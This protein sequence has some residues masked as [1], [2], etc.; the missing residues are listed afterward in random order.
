MF[1][2][3]R[4]EINTPIDPVSIVPITLCY[5]SPFGPTMKADL[6]VT[7]ITQLLTCA[8]NGAPKHGHAMRDVGMIFEGAFAIA[9][10]KFIAVGTREEVE[11]QYSSG[12][13]ID[14]VGKV[15]SPGFVDPH[16]H[17][18]F[19]G[20]RLDEFEL[21][22]QG[23]DY[24]EILKHG[25]GIISTVRKTREA[26]LKEL[27][28]QARCRL[29]KMLGCGTTTAEIKTGYGLDLDTEL[30]MLRVIDEL[31]RT[32]PIEIVPTFL[33]AHAVPPEFKE[34]AEGYIKL[35]CEEMLPA[36]W[37]WYESSSFS[38]KGIP[39]FADIFCERNTFDLNLTR[40]VLEAAA[41]LGFGLK[42]HVDQFTNLGG[43]EY[44]IS[45]NATSID[46]L[47]AISEDEIRLL[48]ASNTIG[49]VIPTEG[50][51]AGKTE[52]A[53]ARR[54]IDAD[55]AVAVTT[56]YNPGSAPCPSQQMAMSIACRYQ[57]LMPAEAFN[58]ATINAAFAV[59]LGRTHG[60]IEVGKA[61]DFAIYDTND[62]RMLVYEFGGPFAG[63]VW[64][65]GRLI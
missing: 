48:A 44:S 49:V 58:A 27:V 38:E 31:N 55:C 19:A 37:S 39:F 50:F 4:S 13:T 5:H 36:A 47:D 12:E 54:M 11:A 63:S 10:G 22:I 41:G 21:K 8:S 24:L 65:Q 40:Q 16:T 51:N 23:A 30:K 60:S 42:A 57:K 35:I 53:P 2:P 25:G 62:Y 15:V 20:D 7:N 46:H 32:H 18:V 9:D 14:A 26:P 61:A 33:A 43:S 52:F 3:I 64:K 1:T 28:E 45:A 59:G 56:D 6:I 17:I 34:N 29:N